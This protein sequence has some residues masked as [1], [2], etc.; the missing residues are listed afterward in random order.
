MAALE[1]IARDVK[2]QVDFNPETVRSYRLLGYENRD[3]ADEKFRDDNED[4]G[5]IG[6]GHTCTALYEIK[7]ADQPSSDLAAT[8]YIRFKDP[9]TREVD[10][11]NHPFYL[12]ACTG[13]F[14]TASDEFRLAAAAAEFAEILRSSYWAK[15][16]SLDDVMKVAAGIRSTAADGTAPELI[17]M[18][19]AADAH[20]DALA[21]R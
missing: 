16:S 2:I 7:L 6:A 11:V 17:E 12:S 1:V 14:E 20:R 10:E 5:E 13:G 15:G 3:V 21:K 8:V 4:G 18:I 9:V 19:R